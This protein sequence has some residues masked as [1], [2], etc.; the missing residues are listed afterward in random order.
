MSARVFRTRAVRAVRPARAGLTLIEL[1]IALALLAALSV[2]V[3][4]LF[5]RSLSLWRRGETRRA[6]L[7]QASA[8]GDLFARDLRGVE[9]GARGDLVAEWV[10][11]DTD[12]D[13]VPETKWP[14]VRFVRAAS[15]REVARVRRETAEEVEAASDEARLIEREAP[16]LIEVVWMV[17]PASL[18]DRDARSEGIVWRGERV[19]ADTTSKSFFAGD[20]FGASN[21]PPAGS[22]DEVGGG[23]LWMGLLF[24]AQTSI[25][26]RGWKIGTELDSAATSWDAWTRARPDVD[27][28]PWNAA[29]P[30]LP[31]P[32]GRAALPR[33]ARLELE[34]ERPVDRLRRTRLSED[35]DTESNLLRIDDDQRMPA[36]ADAHV[37]IDAEWMRVT[38]VD[39]GT[40]TV[41][42][43]ARGTTP[44]AH[45]SGAMVHHGLRLVREIPIATYREDWNL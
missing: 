3:F 30:G 44:T 37:L 27:V 40:A 9:G 41:Q 11:F 42:R 12:A 14:R 22:T 26:N 8:I 2:A 25:V 17:V 45:K 39:R 28:H 24:A 18:V 31:R 32:T 16:G 6:V 1:V 35:L 4:Q 21:R 29:H 38:R 10:R 43:G 19:V 34:I 5:D 13:G 23:V 36:D 33:R 7:E 15:S 20:F